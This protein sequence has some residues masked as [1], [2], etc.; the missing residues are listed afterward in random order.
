MAALI[1]TR[2]RGQKY[3]CTRLPYRTMLKFSP[4]RRGPG[5]RPDRL[6]APEDGAQGCASYLHLLL[7]AA[8]HSAGAQA[9]EQWWRRTGRPTLRRHH[10]SIG[11]KARA[12]CTPWLAITALNSS[13]PMPV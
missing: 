3:V 10:S 4:S 1:G 7:N 5:L 2:H 8:A 11:G 6:L 13:F 9:N 12:A